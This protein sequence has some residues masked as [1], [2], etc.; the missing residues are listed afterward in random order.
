MS[1][2]RFRNLLTQK[3]IMSHVLNSHT[4]ST[5]RNAPSSLCRSLI[6]STTENQRLASTL[7]VQNVQKDEGFLKKFLKKV[8]FL[9]IDHVKIKMSGYLLYEHIADNLDYIETIKKY[10]LPDTFYSWFVITELHIWM[11]AVRAMADDKEGHVLRNSLVEALWGDV[12]KRTKKLGESNPAAMKA[13]I[14]DL[15]EE[16]QA[17]FIA[18]DEGLQSDDMVLAG[19]IWRRV[20]QMEYCAPHHLEGI[21]KH[22]RKHILLL[23]NLSKDQI[24]NVEPV[25]WE[26]MITLQ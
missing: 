14:R 5:Y 7:E 23:D 10:Q 25:K 20:Y 22:I 3:K 6:N 2:P 16:L 26:P 15:S 21:V 9:N 13:Q 1:L 19:A 24:L 18:Y 8:P 11:L 17:S 4:H 12:A